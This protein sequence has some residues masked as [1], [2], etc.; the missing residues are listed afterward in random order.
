VSKRSPDDDQS[1]S[2]LRFDPLFEAHYDAIY[3]YCVRRL[4]RSDAEDAAADVFAVAWRRL[5]EMPEGDTGRAWL[6]GVAYRVVGNQYRS[7]W[8]RSRLSNRL[9]AS[10]VDG[11]RTQVEAPQ[12]GE[13]EILR[14]ALDGLGSADQELLRLSAWDGLSRSE[15]A[16]VLGIRENAVDQRLFRA[17]ARL[18]ARLDRLIDESPN[19]E[20]KEASA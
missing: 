16:Y 4:G 20:P 18:K 5:D 8:R 14:T 3:R 9:V 15:I 19:H 17:R 12:S 13:I 7:R 11:S 6:F 10:S 1:D 2:S